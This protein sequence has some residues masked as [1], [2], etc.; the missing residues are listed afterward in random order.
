[1]TEHEH[2]AGIVV[3]TRAKKYGPGRHPNSRANL[4]PPWREGTSG[5]PEGRPIGSGAPG[6][7]AIREFFRTGIA[8]MELVN[9]LDDDTEPESDNEQSQPIAARYIQCS[10]CTH[11]KLPVIDGLLALGI[12]LRD[13]AGAFGLSRSALHRHKKNHVRLFPQESTAKA[14]FEAEN[15]LYPLLI[16]LR[17]TWQSAAQSEAWYTFNKLWDIMAAHLGDTQERYF[18]QRML[19]A[20]LW[21]F[22]ASGRSWIEY[23]E[24]REDIQRGVEALE[25]WWTTIHEPC[26]QR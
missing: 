1:M 7:R 24:I 6:A 9:D 12:S 23:A 11:E 21:L 13:I 17:R 22:R 26:Q 5:N 10:V 4:R 18:I 15:E 20:C 3:G 14:L 8:S 2:G 16:T 19:T 25:L